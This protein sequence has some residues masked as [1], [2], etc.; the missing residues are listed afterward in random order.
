MVRH[1]SMHPD[2]EG[3]WHRIDHIGHLAV[4]A[5]SRLVGED[6]KSLFSEVVHNLEGLRRTG[7]EEDIP[8]GRSPA[9]VLVA[10]NPGSSLGGIDCTGLTF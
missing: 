7:V 4:R 6:R 2:P 1:T 8:G 5:E 9:G 10:G 3:C